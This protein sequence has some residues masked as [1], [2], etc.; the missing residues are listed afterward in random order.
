MT[1][2]FRPEDRDP[3]HVARIRALNDALRTGGAGGRICITCGIG[4]LSDGLRGQ[5]IDRV[6]HFDSFDPEDDPYGEHDFGSLTVDGISVFWKIDYYD[7][8][9]EC[10]SEDPSDPNQTT[11]VLT[12]LLA[13][14]W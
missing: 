7:A 13:D 4:A 6:R 2:P 11:R 9:M 5:I 12:I 1:L 8:S 3:A 10:G 14:E